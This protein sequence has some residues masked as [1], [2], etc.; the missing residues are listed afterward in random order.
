MPGPLHDAFAAFLDPE[1]AAR[2][3]HFPVASRTKLM[4]DQDRVAA[5]KRRIARKLI[6]PS[7]ADAFLDQ[8]PSEGE[9]LHVVTCGDFVYGDFIVRLIDRHGPPVA[10]VITTLSVSTKNVD[11]FAALFGRV[12]PFPFHLLLSHYFRN[13]NKEIYV[14]LEKRLVESFPDSFHLTIARSHAKLVLVDYGPA[15][16]F[17]IE[18]SGNL[19]TSG[20]IEQFNVHRD[21]ALY[22]FHTGWIDEVRAEYLRTA[23]A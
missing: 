18:G 7:N 2:A 11:A 23:E 6:R 8:L 17:V 12:G 15:G 3:A 20:N 1:K 9:T 4:R 16:C 22:D 19:R 10:L 21:R 5:D 13:T 14:A